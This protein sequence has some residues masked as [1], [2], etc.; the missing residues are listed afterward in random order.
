MVWLLGKDVTWLGKDVTW[1][2]KDVTCIRAHSV[3]PLLESTAA[4]HPSQ[5][6]DSI[7]FTRGHSA[8][9][10]NSK[11]TVVVETGV[12]DMC[13]TYGSVSEMTCI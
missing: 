12:S 8:A 5:S 4:S 6:G 3:V 13:S 10:R 1:L 9:D 11:K 2:G 7:L